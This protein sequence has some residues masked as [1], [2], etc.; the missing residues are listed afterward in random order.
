VWIVL[1]L[2]AGAALALIVYQV[3]RDMRENRSSWRG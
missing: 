3:G 1:L 2:V